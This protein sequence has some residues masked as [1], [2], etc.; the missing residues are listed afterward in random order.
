[1]EALARWDQADS[2]EQLFI[3]AERAGL[4]ERLSRHV[5]AKALGMAGGWVGPLAD[6]RLSINLLADDLAREGFEEWLLREVARSALPPSR[7][8]V[9]ITENWLVE[10]APSAAARLNRLRAA[11]ASIAVDDFGTGYASLGYLTSLP[12]DALKIDKSLVAGLVD[13]ERDRIVVWAMIRLAREL[14]LKV[15]VEGVE[16]SAQLALVSDWG[17]DLYQGFLGAGALDERQ[18]A[19]FVATNDAKAA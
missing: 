8:T 3:R 2:P 16:T 7:L 18:L 10:D 12:L 17:C 14:G 13:G 15:I 9:E 11:G 6:L 1:M 19:R 4:A 5:Q